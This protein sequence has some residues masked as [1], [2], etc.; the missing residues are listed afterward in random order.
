MIGPWGSSSN[1]YINP[2]V[3]LKSVDVHSTQRI[4]GLSFTYVDQNGNSIPVGPWG[5]TDKPP[6]AVR[7]TRSS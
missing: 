7:S 6:K 4:H 1:K 5:S 3:Q 2:P